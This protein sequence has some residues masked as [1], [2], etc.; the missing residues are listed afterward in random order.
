MLPRIRGMFWVAVQ[1][2]LLITWFVLLLAGERYIPTDI[3]RY[4]IDGAGI[5]LSVAGVA[6]A[7]LGLHDLGENLTP[8]PTPKANATLVSTGIFRKVRHPIYGGVILIVTGMT[9]LLPTFLG[10]LFLPIVLIFFYAKSVYEESL[11]QQRFP[12]YQAY[13]AS[14]KRFVPWIW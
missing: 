13:A 7:A 9:L 10:A 5:V 1:F 12:Q 8:S 6:L 4:L 3:P 11:L 2:I 14:A